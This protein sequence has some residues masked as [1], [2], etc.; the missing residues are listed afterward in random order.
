MAAWQILN[1]IKSLRSKRHWLPAYLKPINTH[2]TLV[3]A[4][5]GSSMAVGQ[6]LSL[7]HVTK[8][9]GS[10]TR[11][12]VQRT[13]VSQILLHLN[14]KE[15]ILIKAHLHS[16]LFC[17]IHVCGCGFCYLDVD[18]HLLTP[19]NAFL[20]Y[21]PLFPQTPWTTMLSSNHHSSLI[22]FSRTLSGCNFNDIHQSVK[23][24]YQGK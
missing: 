5:T 3:K 20:L 13:F 8:G 11:D 15:L 21:R 2:P 12:Y 23:L 1:L 14:I 16:I 17:F 24:H 19:Q 4:R 6:T 7:L 22:L 9:K 10:A 18:L